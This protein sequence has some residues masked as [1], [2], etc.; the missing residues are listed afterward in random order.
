ME[1]FFEDFDLAQLSLYMFWLF[2]VGLVIYLQRENMREGYPLETEAGDESVNQGPYPVPDGPKTFKL[3]NGGGEA[4]V[5]D[6][7]RDK[8]DL[9]LERTNVAAGSPLVPK[10]DPMI[11]GVGAAAWAERRDVPE[12]DGHGKPKLRPMRKVE[13]YDVS[14]GRDPRGLN[15][16]SADKKVVG[17][18]ADLWGDVPEQ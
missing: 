3:P 10:G 11:D 16:V 4:H 15:V 17:T 9:A 8:R 5:P 7:S 13:G 1:P 2:F 6:H 18:V 12:L 14:G